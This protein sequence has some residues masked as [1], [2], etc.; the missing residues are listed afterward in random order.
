M[1]L[2][3]LLSGVS[4]NKNNKQQT[5][6]FKKKVLNELDM[7]MEDLLDMKLDMRSKK[8]KF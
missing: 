5:A 4:E 2:K 3:D 1:K 8:L 7:S 6:S